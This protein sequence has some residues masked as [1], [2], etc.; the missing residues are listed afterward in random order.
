MTH[1]LEITRPHIKKTRAAEAA[2]AILIYLTAT[3]RLWT[4]RHS[5]QSDNHRL[6]FRQVRG[7]DAVE[8]PSALAGRS[9]KTNPGHQRY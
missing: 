7:G 5:A 8:L 3:G 4:C 9:M 1:T 2:L 6:A